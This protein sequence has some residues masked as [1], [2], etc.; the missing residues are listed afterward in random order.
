M[1]LNT[2]FWRVTRIGSGKRNLDQNYCS[3]I[4]KLYNVSLFYLNRLV[5]LSFEY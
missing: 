3:F 5:Y 4:F 2:G 1:E